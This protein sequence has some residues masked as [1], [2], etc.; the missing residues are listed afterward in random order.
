VRE[1]RLAVGKHV[2]KTQYKGKHMQALTVFKG[3]K[4]S[5]VDA[6][7]ELN[8]MKVLA[9]GAQS[10]T[11]LSKKEYGERFGLKGQQLRKAHEQYRMSRGI[12]ANGNLAQLMTSGQ[13][14]AEK[15]TTRKD[16]SGFAVAFT[17]AKEF[18]TADPK[19]I[20]QQLTDEELLA[21]LEQRKLATS[22]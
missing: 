16:G 7:I 3:G 6:P 19:V 21:I 15:L 10:M 14:V 13:V 20:A 18:D 17:Y 12:A 4:D 8:R 11:F 5:A 1:L 22:N 9:S 2:T